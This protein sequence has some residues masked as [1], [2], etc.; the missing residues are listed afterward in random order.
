MRILKKVR[1]LVMTDVI[2][3]DYI[4]CDKCKEEID[5]EP[6]DAFKCKF[7]Y[8]TGS[9]Y[10]EGGNGEKQSM[11]LCQDCADDFVELLKSN[12]YN[13]TIEDWDN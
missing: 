4:V 8:K 1:Q 13:V 3:E 10:P 7:V 6:F 2:V 12:G 5:V 11:E 9:C